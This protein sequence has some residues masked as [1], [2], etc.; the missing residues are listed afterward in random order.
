MGN[1]L[2][3]HLNSCSHGVKI[4]VK[5]VN[6]NYTWFYNENQYFELELRNFELELRNFELEVSHKTI[7]SKN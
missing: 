4:E 3:F 1:N 2:H 5:Q 6:D 7:K